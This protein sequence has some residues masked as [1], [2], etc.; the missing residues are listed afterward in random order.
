MFEDG[1]L[2]HAF[3]CLS[4]ITGLLL[5]EGRQMNLIMFRLIQLLDQALSLI[6]IT[7]PANA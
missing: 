4:I 2:Y 3:F 5:L 7:A 1:G 6:G